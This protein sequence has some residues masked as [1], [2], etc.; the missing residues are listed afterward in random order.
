[1]N[2]IITLIGWFLW[3]WAEFSITK[4]TNEETGKTT[5]FRDYMKSHFET[6]IGSFVCM[7]ALLI[8]GYRQ[9]DIN[10]LGLLIGVE[11]NGWNDLY[12]FAAGGA[13]DAVI[14]IF[15]KIRNFF[16]ARK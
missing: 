7:F 4:E 2:F 10:P 5:P 9:M 13:W 15:K 16:A 14:F 1:M 6:W 11:V 3:N 8:I 12:L